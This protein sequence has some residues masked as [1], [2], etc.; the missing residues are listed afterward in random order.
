MSWV[1]DVQT[2]DCSRTSSARAERLG[3]ELQVGEAVLLEQRPA[4]RADRHVVAD[5]L[6]GQREHLRAGRLVLEATGV[7][8]ERGV[9][10]DRGGVVQREPEPVDQPAHEHAARGGLRVDHVDAAVPVVR[11]VVVD[12]RSARRR[13]RPLAREAAEA[14]E[15]A[16][17]ERDHDLGLGPGTRA[18]GVSSSR[19]GQVA[20]VRRHEERLGERRDAAPT[21]GAQHVVQRE[22]RAERVAVGRDVTGERDDVRLRR[23]ASRPAS[24]ASSTLSKLRASRRRSSSVS[25]GALVDGADDLFDP[26]ALRDRRIFAEAQLGHVLEP[27]LASEHGSQA[28]GSPTRS[29]AAVVDAAPRACRAPSSRRL[30]SRRSGLTSTPVIVTNPRRGSDIRSS[31]SASISRTTSFT[32]ARPRVLARRAGAWSRRLMTRSQARLGV[33]QLDVG[34]CRDEA[35]HRCHHLLEVPGTAVDQR[36][37]DRRPAATGPGGRPRPPT[38]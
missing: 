38:P 14:V 23:S 21:G 27:H 9:E 15:G 8:D 2:N 5:E 6:A 26:L 11:D 32:R 13:P 7:A 19:P 20:V 31:S 28:R 25:H 4:E 22:R 37:P 36:D 16:A 10:A 34:G 17:V 24:S 1:T 35:L 12:A 30:R 3:Q 18:G 29:A 33:E